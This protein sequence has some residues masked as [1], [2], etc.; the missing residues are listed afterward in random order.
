MG[1]EQIFRLIRN[2]LL[3]RLLVPEAFGLMAI[4]IS[5]N[6]A[7][8]TVTQLSIKEAIIQNPKGHE[9]TY[10]NGAWWLSASRAIALYTVVYICAP[11]ISNFYNNSELTWLVRIGFLTVV[12]NGLMSPGA[13]VSVKNMKFNKWAIV[14]NGG[15]ILGILITITLAY[16]YRN[17]WA[18][19]IGNASEAVLRLILSYGVCPFRPRFNFDRENLSTL[20][21]FTRGM[22]G[23]PILFFIWMNA[24][25]FTIGKVLTMTELGMYALAASAARMPFNFLGSLINQLIFPA[26]SKKQND[27]DWLNDQIIRIT[28]IISFIGFPLLF[29]AIF[30][31]SEILEILYGSKYAAV[32]IP[33]AILFAT[34]LIKE[35]GVPIA[36]VYIS[37]GQPGLH[38]YF[39]AIR[40]LVIIILIYPAVNIFGL[41][42]AA[43]AGLISL[44]IANIFQIYRLNQITGI[45]IGEYFRIYL[46]SISLSSLALI[47]WC[48]KIMISLPNAASNLILGIL[49]CVFSYL[50]ILIFI[51]LTKFKIQ[52]LQL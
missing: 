41:V 30:Y 5:V 17:V 32:S 29:A 36:T 39:T 9:Q 11:L 14:S 44:L 21:K 1:L 15:N 40:A 27:K 48:F 3:A 34:S 49:G 35:M 19:V 12:F 25:V 23:L 2:M 18:L 33:F 42:G 38:R 26:F 52:I 8:E 46:L 20:F 31:G 6:A 45:K 37:T 43:S 24:D 47:I 51:K 22:F 7:F 16:F 13:Y 50:T 4:I 28:A 10:L